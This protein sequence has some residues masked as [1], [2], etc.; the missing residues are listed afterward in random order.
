[1]WI[2]SI[3]LCFLKNRE[4]CIKLGFYKKLYLFFIIELLVHKLTTWKSQ[5]L[6]SFTLKLIMHIN[7]FFIVVSSESAFA[8]NINNHYDLFIFE[9]AKMNKVSINIFGLKIKKT[10][11]SYAFDWCT[12]S[13][14]KYFC[15]D[16]SHIKNFDKN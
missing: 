13:F 4:S 12:T 1:M 10:L 14:E 8:S 11:G 16:T 15:D 9:I 6:E 3:Y 2:L 5:N 7:H